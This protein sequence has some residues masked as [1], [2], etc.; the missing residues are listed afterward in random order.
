MKNCTRFFTQEQIDEI[1]MRLAAINGAKDSQFEKAVSFGND[2]QVA[3]V[4]Q[5]KNKRIEIGKLKNWLFALDDTPTP[6]S[7]NA[8]TSDGIYTYIQ[9]ILS[10]IISEGKYLYIQ[11]DSDMFNCLVYGPGDIYTQGQYDEYCNTVY[12][13]INNGYFIIIDTSICVAG[14]TVDPQYFSLSYISPAENVLITAQK[15][16][17]IWVKGSTSVN[18]DKFLIDNTY[19]DENQYINLSTINNI[20]ANYLTKA[21]LTRLTENYPHQGSTKLVTSGGIWQAIQNAINNTTSQEELLIISDDTMNGFFSAPGSPAFNQSCEIVYNACENNMLI[22]FNNGICKCTFNETE[23]NKTFELWVVTTENTYSICGQ[24]SKISATDWTRYRPNTVTDNHLIT[25]SQLNTTLQAYYTKSQVDA[26]S[27]TLQ[28]Y[29]NS[30]TQT[31]ARLRA[32][33]EERML[34]TPKYH[35]AN[36]LLDEIDQQ[37]RVTTQTSEA[38][39]NDRFNS[40]WWA[41][42]HDKIIT[43][44]GIPDIFRESDITVSS[45]DDATSITVKFFIGGIIS[46][47]TIEKKY[48]GNV[49][50]VENLYLQVTAT[51][52]QI[53]KVNQVVSK[54]V[55]TTDNP[56]IVGPSVQKYTVDLSNNLDQF[57]SFSD[58]TSIYD[59]PL[60]VDPNLNISPLLG[61]MKIT[62]CGGLVTDKTDY[63]NIPNILGNPALTV[64][65]SLVDDT[66]LLAGGIAISINNDDNLVI[67]Y[68]ETNGTMHSLTVDST[69]IN[70]QIAS[71][72]NSILKN[73][74]IIRDTNALSF[75][76]SIF[77]CTV[78]FNGITQ[79]TNFFM[80]TNNSYQLCAINQVSLLEIAEL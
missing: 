25:S 17:G 27:A 47:Y 76:L 58:I 3:I 36:W 78:Q 26:I 9:N 7:E 29:I 68:G 38:T 33:Y 64:Y 10:S 8:V 6:G 51:E 4:Q 75:L 5:G 62:K 45:P 21:E 79:D 42:K 24:Y 13:A 77:Q 74:N 37:G 20:L 43:F 56:T 28:N 22:V 66:T 12:E 59:V 34:S 41:V 44:Y 57:H 50:S 70:D 55:E 30:N 60:I 23:E 67:T 46:S 52:D 31:I 72:L 16:N 1:R 80:R 11:G 65:G 39:P 15:S 14:S 2:D 32:D 61:D 49:Q 48:I 40:M 73:F 71:F 19:L 54:V 63:I 53:D 18:L 69:T 35:K